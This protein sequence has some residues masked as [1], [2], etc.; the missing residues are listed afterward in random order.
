VQIQ[1]VQA[2]NN[3]L[4]REVNELKRTCDELR[5]RSRAVPTYHTYELDRIKEE[6]A[7]LKKQLDTLQ[8]TNL[9]VHHQM[10]GYE[11]DF[12][13]ERR[14]R[15]EAKNRLDQVKREKEELQTLVNQLMGANI[16]N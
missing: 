13:R 14:D 1:Q 16:R 11:E 2:D 15:E 4:V 7:S 8:E 5:Q 12:K 10:T 6:N 3:D 9:L